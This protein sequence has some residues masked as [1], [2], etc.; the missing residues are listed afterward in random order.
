MREIRQSG[1]SLIFLLLIRHDEWT[2]WNSMK[3]HTPMAFVSFVVVD[4]VF[5]FSLFLLSIRGNSNTVEF[6][7]YNF[8]SNTGKDEINVSM[9]PFNW[10]A[11]NIVQ[12]IR[13]AIVESRMKLIEIKMNARGMGILIY[14]RLLFFFFLLRIVSPTGNKRMTIAGLFLR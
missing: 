10:N 8:Y 6:S 9:E 3:I 5:F 7:W 4:F 2:S 1:I 13:F 11:Y 12:T 14:E